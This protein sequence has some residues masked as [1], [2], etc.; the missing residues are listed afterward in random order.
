MLKRLGR[1]RERHGK[2]Q[3]DALAKY[4]VRLTYRQARLARRIGDTNLSAG[5]RAAIEYAAGD[6][7]FMK[8]LEKNPD[9][10]DKV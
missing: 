9:K 1:P 3:E 4:D 2:D 10:K 8:G 5:I 7:E 6:E